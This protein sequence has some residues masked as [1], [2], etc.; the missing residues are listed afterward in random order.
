MLSSLHVKHAGGVS[1]R[2][3]TDWVIEIDRTGLGEV[4]VDLWHIVVV[5][6]FVRGPGD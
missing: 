1:R 4:P 2:F 6:G 5:P 3:E